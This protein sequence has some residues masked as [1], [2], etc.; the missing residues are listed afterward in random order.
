VSATK[1]IISIVD[2]D[3]DNSKLFRMILSENFCEYD[4]LSFNDSVLALEHFTENQGAYAMVIADF[5]MAGL[6]GLELLS[7]IKNAN[8]NVR[9]IVIS[10]FNF[11]NQ[12]FRD[13]MDLGII[14]SPIGKPVTIQR[15]CERVRSELEKYQSEIPN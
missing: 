14:D 11:E 15:L 7:R 1:K 2:D 10:G 13:C 12:M 6:N 4:V 3:E 8:P 9:T 5:R